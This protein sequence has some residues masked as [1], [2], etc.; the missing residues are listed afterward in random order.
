MNA[1]QKGFMT[2]QVRRHLEECRRW[3]ARGEI[4]KSELAAAKARLGQAW[5]LRD[6][7][8]MY[9]DEGEK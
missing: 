2:R 4:F 7:L 1:A 8:R 3:Q 6:M 9:R 5:Y